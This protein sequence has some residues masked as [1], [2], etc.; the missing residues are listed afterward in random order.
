M[1]NK[2]FIMEVME[3]VGKDEASKLKEDASSMTPTQIIEMERAI[4]DFDPKKDY[5]NSPVGTPV[6]DE[7]QVWSLIQ[8][9]N[10]SYYG[11]RPSTLRA[12]WG[13]L[14]T[15]N[16]KKAKAW[17]APLGTSGMYMQDECYL[18]YDGHV[19]KSLQNNNVYNH[20]QY[21]SYWQDLGLMSDILDS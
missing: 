5:T 19:Y 20:E 12:L 2:E 10:A 1:T 16:P 6:L 7:G 18:D 17:V 21:P 3:K 15:K 11:G 9:H 4:Q 8:P 13:L 14:H